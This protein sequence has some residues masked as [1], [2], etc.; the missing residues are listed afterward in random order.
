[1]RRTRLINIYN[2]ARVEGGGYTMD[3]IDWS[4]LIVGRTI[5]AGDFNARSPAWDPWVVGRRNAG[6]TERLIE[7][8][9]LIINNN[10]HRP[11]RW[12]KDCKSIIDL[13]L[14]TRQVG[15]LTAWDVDPDLATTSDH[16]V[17]TFAW[18]QLRLTA[19]TEETITTP[20]W[21]TNRLYADKQAMEKAA[22]HW[23]T[24]SERRLLV[25]PHATSEEEL[26]AEASWL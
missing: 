20:N 9:D 3:H 4:R 19:A 13:T 22:E 2:K 21:N 10:D 1:M 15:A 17:I 5:L 7:R 11:T 24:L 12:G 26:E 8:H 23:R 14:S 16:E 25:E 6:T 18:A